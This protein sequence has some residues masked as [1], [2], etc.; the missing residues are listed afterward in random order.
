MGTIQESV[1]LSAYCNIQMYCFVLCI[2]LTFL[3]IFLLCCRQQ[4]E[5]TRNP[6]DVKTMMGKGT[7]AYLNIYS[8]Q[9]PEGTLNENQL[10]QSISLITAIVS[11]YP[12]LVC[13]THAQQYLQDYPLPHAAEITT[14]G[15]IQKWMYEFHNAVNIRL[16]KPDYSWSQ[17]ESEWLIPYK[18]CGDCQ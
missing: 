8:A 14:A 1:N 16:K 4:R 5:Q 10:E 6:I 3:C 18:N 9:L 7:W 12:C 17:F 2:F 11:N 15:D 13:K